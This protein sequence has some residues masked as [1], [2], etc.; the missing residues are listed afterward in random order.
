M[1]TQM[2][3][4]R[5]ILCVDDEPYNLE[6]LKVILSYQDYDV[7]LVAT[8]WETLEKIR[9]EHVDICLLDV[10]MPKMDGFEVCRRIKSEE[11]HHTIPVVLITSLNDKNSRISGITG[12]LTKPVRQSQLYDC[13]ALVLSRANQASEV[14]KTPVVSK[15]TVTRH[16]IAENSKHKPNRILLADDNIINQKVARAMLNK[17]GYKADVVFNGREAAEHFHLQTMIWY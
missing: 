6:L 4:R 13:I 11:A 10:M 14:S 2:T 17:L 15:G 12:Y 8:G 16:T 9:T 3:K 1:I 5:K 7:L